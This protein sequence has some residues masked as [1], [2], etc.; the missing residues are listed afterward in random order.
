MSLVREGLGFT[1]RGNREA[2]GFVSQGLFKGD[3]EVSTRK[4]ER[5][6]FV[7][8]PDLAKQESFTEMGQNLSFSLIFQSL[9]SATAVM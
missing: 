7:L 2:R 5:A 1:V 3:G 9:T 4:G 8:L 6:W